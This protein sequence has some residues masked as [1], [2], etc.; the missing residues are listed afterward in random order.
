MSA[1]ESISEEDFVQGGLRHSSDDAED[2]AKL[3]TADDTEVISGEPHEYDGEEEDDD[4]EEDEDDEEDFTISTDS[5][6]L[7]AS[8]RPETDNEKKLYEALEKQILFAERIYQEVRKLKAFCK[9]RKQPYKRKRKETGAPVRA[10]SAYNIFM[11]EKFDQISQE[12]KD[13]LR[14]DDKDVQLKRLPP[15]S[16]V[17]KTASLWKELPSDQKRVYFEK[18]K[19]DKKRYQEEMASYNPPTKG[20]ARKRNKTGY[21]IFFSTHVAQMKQSSQ[22]VPS[23][24]GSVARTVGNAWKKLTPEQRDYYEQEASRLN[25]FEG[26]GETGK[27][28]S[29]I[30]PSGITTNEMDTQ[31]YAS[32]YQHPGVSLGQQQQQSQQQQPNFVAHPMFQ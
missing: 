20:M 12:N 18:A 22:G 7:L 21:N 8:I 11:K 3:G 27:G 2:G 24:R 23:E 5:M 30:G 4:D 9:K 19:A 6:A 28:L 16:I 25:K 31:R 29:N 14:S 32:T 13:A 1:N 15:A 10:L 17:S 26:E